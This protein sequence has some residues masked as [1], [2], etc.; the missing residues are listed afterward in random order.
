MVTRMLPSLA[1]IRE[2]GS[3]C[4]YEERKPGN[5]KGPASPSPRMGED[6]VWTA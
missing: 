6:G 2:S 1:V 4:L 3:P 5:P